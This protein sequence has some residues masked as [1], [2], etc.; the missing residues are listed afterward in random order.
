LD[1][2]EL[3]AK[4]FGEVLKEQ[5]EKLGETQQ[6]LAE[7]MGWDDKHLGKVERGKKTTKFALPLYKLF[8]K[9]DISLDDMYVE[10]QKRMNTY[11]KD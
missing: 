10:I 8:T 7:I 6:N 11:K 2:K 4:V 1:E 9:T 3:F 5:R